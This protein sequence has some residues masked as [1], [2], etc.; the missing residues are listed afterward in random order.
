[1]YRAYFVDDEPH[2]LEGLVS[3]PLFMESGYQVAGFSTD[4]LTAEKEIK[5]LS[6]DVVFTDLKMPKLTGV[7]LMERLCQK[8]A[9]CEFVIISA[10]GEFEAS[11]NF[12][13]LGGFDYLTKPVADEDLQALLY[14]L[15]GK[16]AVK[17]SETF[18]LNNTPSPE[19][20]KVIA[21]LS[22]NL[23]DKHTLESISEK[24]EINSTYICDLF[25]SDMGTT[26]RAFQMRLRMETA[27][28][29]LKEDSQKNVKE[30]AAAC[31]YDYL[32]FHGTPPGMPSAYSRDTF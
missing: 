29:M 19:L 22:E 16:L 8:D 9:R 3:N 1:M 5:K 4:P 24:F 32:I 21:Y 11:R 13:T 25:S 14:K 26:F 27:A 17:K 18:T 20:N 10:Y 15:S 28:R 23:T 7:E 6:P 12:F 31:G 2:V 30:I